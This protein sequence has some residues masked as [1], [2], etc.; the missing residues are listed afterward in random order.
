MNATWSLALAS[1]KRQRRS[2]LLLLGT[3]VLSTVFLVC[4]CLVG[5]SAIN[6]ATE[7]RLDMYGEQKVIVWGNPE[8]DKYMPDFLETFNVWNRHGVLKNY[9]SFEGLGSKT[10]H[11]GSLDPAAAEMLRIELVSGKMPE[12][13]GQAAIEV[14]TARLLGQ[15][16][17]LGDK[18]SLETS[19]GT[20][21]LTVCG[22]VENY[23]AVKNLEGSNGGDGFSLYPTVLVSELPGYP[24]EGN[25]LE[26]AYLLDSDITDFYLL[27]SAL[28]EGFQQ[29]FNTAAYP[30]GFS[31]GGFDIAE[32]TSITLSGMVLIGGIIL[33][34]TA[35]VT[36]NGFLMSVDRRRRQIS[37][38]R[39]IGATRRQAMNVIMAEA[40]I[41]VAVGLPLGLCTGVGT[42]FLA[43]K[44][45]SALQNTDI[46]WH[47]EW[48]TL[49]LASA[50][51]IVCVLISTLVPAAKASK[52]PPIVAASPSLAARKRRRKSPGRPVGALGMMWISVKNS[53]GR[54]IMTGLTFSLVII[55]A[56]V[57]A[58][59][60]ETLGDRGY[61]TPDVSISPEANGISYS[62]EEFEMHHA[63]FFVNYEALTRY[64]SLP[65]ELPAGISR[66][67]ELSCSWCYIEPRFAVSV[68][69]ADFDGYLNGFFVYDSKLLPVELGE[70]NPDGIIGI[71]TGSYPHASAH[72]KYGIDPDRYLLSTYIFSVSPELLSRLEANVV[73]GRI[74]IDAIM[75]GD[76][77]ILT[78]PNYEANYDEYPFHLAHSILGSGRENV[79]ENGIFYENRTWAAGDTLELTWV[80]IGLDGKET[81]ETREVTVGATVAEGLSAYGMPGQI[82]G[83]YVGTETLNSIGAP[84]AIRDMTLYF[85]DDADIANG[86]EQ[87]INWLNERYPA[88]RTETQ[89][90]VNLA[91]Q[92]QRRLILGLVAMVISCL[93]ALG[94][95]GLVNTASVRINSRATQINRLRSI[96]MTKAQVM[97]MLTG[98]GGIIG[99]AAAAVGSGITR[100]I[101]P[102]ITETWRYP[103]IA[104]TIAI[105]S[106]A[107][108]TL[109]VA[110]V[111]VPAREVLKGHRS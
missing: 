111:F 75:R 13:P 58:L 84:H 103:A 106:A 81:V 91:E 74:D 96:G 51:C 83:L 76:E 31:V 93:V 41:L 95:L 38:L 62:G 50:L 53:P 110:T 14:G 70:I 22:I 92:Q 82:F 94:L 109:A 77:V 80:N 24:F 72:E 35:S 100:L 54:T 108:I 73:S 85:P 55:V 9:A 97:L 88:L 23:A 6:S 42:S 40:A 89:T 18:I 64:Y 1:L 63:P 5:S 12:S 28:P 47:F 86:E 68:K 3:V 66:D 56:G 25:A 57:A 2:G 99:I 15:D 101:L 30:G 59:I 21:E 33:V 45:F 20:V 19:L 16:I 104:P 11:I 10:L 71:P 39:C 49:P 61:S 107:C 98:E 27:S 32:S 37:L 60:S 4:M 44:L 17:S 48:W 79:L 43:V 90:D 34:C 65:L 36:M 87:V 52:Q 69:K 29:A 7:A 46:L 8:A 102:I 78:L 67:I 26:T 105:A